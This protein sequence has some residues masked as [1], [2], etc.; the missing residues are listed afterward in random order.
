MERIDWLALEIAHVQGKWKVVPC[1]AWLNHLRS[2]LQSLH[3]QL[4]DGETFA[5]ALNPI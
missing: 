2:P 3:M 4:V 5:M 1:V